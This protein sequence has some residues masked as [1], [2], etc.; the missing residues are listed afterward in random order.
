LRNIH[1]PGAGRTQAAQ[2]SPIAEFQFS[3]STLLQRGMENTTDRLESTAAQSD[4]RFHKG[5]CRRTA[6][7]D[8]T[9]E[10]SKASFD[11]VDLLTFIDSEI[12]FFVIAP[13]VVCFIAVVVVSAVFYP[14][15]GLLGFTPRKW[16]R[17]SD[18]FSWWLFLRNMAIIVFLIALGWSG[19]IVAFTK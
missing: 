12:A 4:M 8:K 17:K 14:I 19:V 3:G 1:P 18:N 7:T 9:N 2:F 16:W 13:V 10:N 5:Y 15:A 11:A 6:V